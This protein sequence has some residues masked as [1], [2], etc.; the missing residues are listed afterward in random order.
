[1]SG[2]DRDWITF[3]ELDQA[4]ARDKGSA[5]RAFKRLSAGW[6]EERDF[7]VLKAGEDQEQILTL[8]S[9]GRLYAGTV[10]AVLLSPA[11]ARQIRAALDQS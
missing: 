8:K 7:R 10:N 1:M 11:A 5:F 9:A 2:S 6:Q 4:C 3:R